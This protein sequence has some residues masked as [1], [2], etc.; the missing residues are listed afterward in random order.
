[1]QKLIRKQ[2]YAGDVME[3][4]RAL[5]SNQLQRVMEGGVLK[6]E[7]TWNSELE[8]D[9]GRLGVHLVE[10]SDAMEV[11]VCERIKSF[12]LRRS[13]QTEKVLA[14]TLER[15]WGERH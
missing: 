4:L 15:A 5:P 14:A 12:N 6:F 13:R 7:L 2:D 10:V 3:Q 8:L 9:A 1:M 11:E